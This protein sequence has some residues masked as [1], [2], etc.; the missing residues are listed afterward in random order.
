[1]LGYIPY[2]KTHPKAS[3]SHDRAK[4]GIYSGN[5]LLCA[6]S[7]AFD[8][9]EATILGI[10]TDKAD[11]PQRNEPVVVSA[12]L[13]GNAPAALEFFLDGESV[14]GQVVSFASFVTVP[15]T[16][17]SATPRPS[18]LEGKS[19]RRWL[20]PGQRSHFCL[21]IWSA[22]PGRAHLQRPEYQRWI[23]SHCHCCDQS[24]EEPLQSHDVGPL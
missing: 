10:S 23:H 9:G 2:R 14:G 20:K 3:Q 18:Y 11:Y 6:G 19:Y 24:G 4:L 7:E 21:W 16:L 22:G 15:F 13:Y 17:P 1:M 12:S 5:M 8:M